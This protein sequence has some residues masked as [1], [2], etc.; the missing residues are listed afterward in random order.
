VSSDGADGL[1]AEVVA[2]LSAPAPPASDPP[3]AFPFRTPRP[4]P[5]VG[6]GRPGPASQAEPR[7][8]AG[9]GGPGRGAGAGREGR[10]GAGLRGAGH[11]SYRRALDGFEGYLK[12]RTC[13]A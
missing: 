5:A 4:S 11:E 9:A 3:A 10:R 7:A 12:A 1:P 8:A 2:L 6:P 13:V